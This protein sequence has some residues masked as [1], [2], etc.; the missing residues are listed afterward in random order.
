MK[1]IGKLVIE[2]NKFNSEI[3]TKLSIEDKHALLTPGERMKLI[4]ILSES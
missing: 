1:A 2:P 3:F 4:H